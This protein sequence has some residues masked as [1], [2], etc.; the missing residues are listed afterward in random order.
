LGKR[1]GT[2][3]VLLSFFIFIGKSVALAETDENVAVIGNLGAASKKVWPGMV[4]GLKAKKLESTEALNDTTAWKGNVVSYVGD[5]VSGGAYESQYTYIVEVDGI[6]V[7]GNLDDELSGLRS[8]WHRAIIKRARTLYVPTARE[9]EINEDSPTAYVAVVE[10]GCK[11]WQRKH[12]ERGNQIDGI[13]VRVVGLKSSFFAGA[14]GQGTNLEAA[15]ELAGVRKSDE[16]HAGDAAKSSGGEPGAA[17]GGEPGAPAGGDAGAATDGE[18]G[19]TVG[20]AMRWVHR[21]VAWAMSFLLVL[22]GTLA[23]VHGASKF[24]P[25]VQ[26][27]KVKLGDYLGYAGIAF[28]AIGCVWFGAALL[29]PLVLKEPGFGSLPSIALLL[30]GAA[31]GLDLLR[32]KGKLK[33]ETASMIQPLA[34]L[35]GLACFPAALVHIIFWDRM[36]L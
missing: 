4:K 12:G 25:Q 26:E 35:L 34:I 6:P 2:L 30:A 15:E 10:G 31:V 11:V 14:C 28:A 13:K 18:A 27:Q 32:A 36:L 24:V 20:G 9:R 1:A 7:C 23:L 8:D 16:S 21:I 17:A 19:A 33:D 3:L 29:L 5:N 22:A